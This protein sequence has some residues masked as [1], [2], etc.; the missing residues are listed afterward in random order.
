MGWSGRL[1]DCFFSSDV[2][3]EVINIFSENGKVNFVDKKIINHLK[4][5]SKNKIIIVSKDYNTRKLE[6][7][8]FVEFVNYI[9]EQY[10]LKQMVL[11]YGNCHTRVIK[12]CLQQNTEFSSQYVIYPWK[13]IQEIANPAYFKSEVLDWCDIFIHQSIRKENRY[14]EDYSSDRIISKL[15]GNARII[16]IPNLYHLPMHLFPAFDEGEFYYPL[17]GGILFFR[18]K[19]LDDLFVIEKGNIKKII[20]KYKLYDKWDPDE[21]QKKYM[22]FKEIVHER[23]KQWDIKVSD[24]IDS[25]FR[26]KLLFYDPN[27]P[28][29]FF[30]SWIAD[31]ILSLLGVEE[32][33]DI[34]IYSE[35]DQFQ[36]PISKYIYDFYDIKYDYIQIY[37]KHT[38]NYF[39]RSELNIDEYIKQYLSC[40]WQNKDI[41]HSLRIKSFSVFIRNYS[42]E[43]FEHVLYRAVSRCVP[44]RLKKLAKKRI[45]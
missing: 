44:N 25:N 32:K 7:N 42:F 37:R 35:M 36:I 14:G 5:N 2:S 18:D 26:D 17:I 19:I 22:H 6:D 28:T 16:S 41:R 8:G 38:K 3:P 45:V 31:N 4:T 13:P 21:I 10:L 12:E 20:Q 23:E 27:H 9:R 11:I 40:E 1:E 39:G 24:F 34:I 15:N 29:S 33:N 43:V 30:L